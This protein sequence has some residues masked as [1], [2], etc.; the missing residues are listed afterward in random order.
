MYGLKHCADKTGKVKL[1]INVDTCGNKDSGLGV[2]YDKMHPYQQEVF[3]R[4]ISLINVVNT[5]VA[6]YNPVVFMDCCP[7]SK[8]KIPFLSMGNARITGLNYSMEDVISQIPLEKIHC[9]PKALFE[10][11]RV[12]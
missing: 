1:Y 4:F 8:H 2:Y 9:L 7:F 10:Y 3:Q 5:K 11:L 12:M 6:E